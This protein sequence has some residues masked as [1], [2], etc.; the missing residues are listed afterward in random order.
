MAKTRKMRPAALDGDRVLDADA[1]ADAAAAAAAAPAPGSAL[2]AGLDPLLARFF[3]HLADERRLSP[4]TQSNYRRDLERI[5]R[6]RLEQGIEAWSGLRDE[7]IRRY[8]AARHR[9]GIGGRSLAR[10]LSALR[11]FFDFLLRERLVSHNP[12]RGLRAPKSARRLPGSLDADTL[13]ALLDSDTTV[14]ANA[15]VKAS[16][17]AATKNEVDNE[18]LTLRDTAMVELLYSSGLRLAELVAIDVRDIDPV[19][20]TL[21][22]VGKGSKTRRVPV[23]KAALQ[24]VAAWQAVRPLLAAP[25]EPALFVSSRG[26][27]I[28]PRTVQARLKR[29]AQQRGSGRN[30]HPH[31]LRHSFASHLLESS[32]D[33]RAV[34][35]LLGHADIATTQVYTHL[36][37]QH[38]AQ[39]Y[40][41]AH[42]RARKRR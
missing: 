41:K 24:A 27:R 7:A 32:G 39:V 22:V 25:D 12:A 4:H 17:G 9:K 33:L 13:C 2:E 29:W 6:W 36:D 15:G 35:E 8:I 5:S 11:T 40:D 3:A 28:H 38:L 34:Q 16:A 30:L 37:F 31:L 26:G 18:P 23:G 1:A 21:T 10:E 14:D 42:P 20:A 19:D